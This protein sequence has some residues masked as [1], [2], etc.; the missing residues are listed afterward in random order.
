MC[1]V[2]LL[3]VEERRGRRVYG[4]GRLLA[5][6]GKGTFKDVPPS[7]GVNSE[8]ESASVRQSD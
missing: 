2:S 8:C 5:A 1:R 4:V 7:A 3:F 6:Y